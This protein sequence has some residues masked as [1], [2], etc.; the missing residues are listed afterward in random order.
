M[1]FPK[2]VFLI[3]F[4]FL[5][6]VSTLVLSLDSNALGSKFLDYAKKAEVFDWMVQIRRKLHEHPELAYDEVET[7]KLIRKELDNLGI[8]YTYPVA[9][10]GVIGKVGTGGPPFVA[11]RAD[12]D[13]LPIQEEVEWEHKSKIPG[14][15]HACGHDAHVAMLLGAA[16]M[17]KTQEKE[18][19]GTIV[20]VFQPAEEGGAGAVKVLDSGVLDN[21]KAIFGL[22]V[23]NG[24]P[25]GVTASRAGSFMAGSGNFE[26]V[27]KGQ[28]G[29]GALPHLSKDPVVAAANVIISLQ[30][31]ISREADPADSQVVTVATLE[32]S[33][34]FNVIPETAK[35]GG[36]FRG[37]STIRHLK[38]RI[39]EVIVSQA[40]VSRCTAAVD[41]FED[42]KPLYPA[43]INDDALYA[44]YKGVAAEMLGSER[45]LEP[46][47]LTVSEDFAF[48]QEK[49]PGLFFFIGIQNQ[50]VGNVALHSPK[51]EIAE[52]AFPYGAALH[53]T[54][55][56]TYLNHVLIGSQSQP[57]FY[58]RDEL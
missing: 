3:Y 23:A 16:K 8:P 28:G 56:T 10:T 53:A 57:N 34:A 27:I 11:L 2:W 1:A 40:V 20:L 35:F 9:K 18:L 52:D 58:N 5:M 44:L 36:T 12:M 14:K 49:L 6:V 55:A 45:V 24:V 42:E 25:V 50:T 48:Y 43:V 29:H 17:L 15:M 39:Q 33:N 46:P 54:L 21:V 37:F 41:F 30:Q 31:L 32:G 51:F 47:A 19:Q 22:H 26:A 7:S 13:A 4:F 38:E